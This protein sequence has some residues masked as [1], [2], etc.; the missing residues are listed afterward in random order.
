MVPSLLPFSHPRADLS[1]CR[2][3]LPPAATS[4]GEL[5]SLGSQQKLQSQL[6]MRQMQFEI[7][8]S[9]FLLKKKPCKSHFPPIMG[10]S[11]LRGGRTGFS[12][13]AE[14]GSLL[15]G[16]DLLLREDSGS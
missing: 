12:A 6:E 5:P 7:Q 1:P 2:G 11:G 10:R 8:H 14:P 13:V 16:A 9:S 15:S 3:P 4:H